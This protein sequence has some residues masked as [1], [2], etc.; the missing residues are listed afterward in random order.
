MK[1]FMKLLLGTSLILLDQSDR[2]TTH[3]RGRLGDQL[4]DLRD[5][6][7]RKYEAAANRVSRARKALR[8]REENRAIRNSLGF[9]VGVGVGVGV[10]ML[11]DPAK[12]EETRSVLTHRV[13]KIG[14]DVRRRFSSREFAPTGTGD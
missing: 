2:A 14:N 5:L 1:K 6:A 3:A 9:L 11:T 10:A 4:D 7:Q 12:G 13:Q 8:R